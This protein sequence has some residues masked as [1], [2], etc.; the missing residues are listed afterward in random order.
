[1]A[2]CK[3]MLTIFNAEHHVKCR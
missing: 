2:Q 1:M 3:I